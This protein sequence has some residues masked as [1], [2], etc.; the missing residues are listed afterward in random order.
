MITPVILFTVL[1]LPF[2]L[3]TVYYRDMEKSRFAGVIG[4]SLMFIVAGT[5]HFLRTDEMKKL[6]PS[7]WPHPELLII[8]TGILEYIV[9]VGVLSKTYRKKFGWIAVSLF[10]IFLPFNVYGAFHS[11]GPG[12]HEWGLKYLFLRVPLQFLFIVWTW[13]FCITDI[14]YKEVDP[15]IDTC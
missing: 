7:S 14:K 5:A 4:L 2:W 11:I 10:I 12:G 8:F 9:A 1:I 6:I 3:A 13:W 15:H